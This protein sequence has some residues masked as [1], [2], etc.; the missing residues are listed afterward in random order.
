MATNITSTQNPRIQEVLQ[1]SRSRKRREA[2]L[3]VIEGLRE[4]RKAL[5]NGYLFK[6]AFFCPDIISS[7]VDKIIGEFPS[8]LQLFEISRHVFEKIAYRDNNDGLIV[9]AVPVFR[10]PEDYVPGENPLVMVLESVEKPG[11]LGALLRTADAAG[12]DAV[13]VCDPETDI[14]NPNVIRSSLGCIFTNNV[15]SCSTK[16]AI[17]YLKKYGIRIYSAALQTEVHYTDADY[18]YPSAIV[19]GSEAKG[20]SVLWRQN[21]DQIIRIPMAGEADSLNISVSAGI[22]IFEA[23]RQRKSH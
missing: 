7:E 8:T 15:I 23:L 20:L 2:N 1:L 19:F 21:A 14:Y 13:M 16:E 3:F 12:I 4:I 6:S 18:R 11:N 10:K 22:I 5:S 17:N 9:L